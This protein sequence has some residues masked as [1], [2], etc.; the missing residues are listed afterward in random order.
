MKRCFL[1]L[2]AKRSR[3]PQRGHGPFCSN[4]PFLLRRS[5]YDAATSSIRYDR[6]AVLSSS[7]KFDIYVLLSINHPAFVDCSACVVF[8]PSL[9]PLIFGYPDEQ[10]VVHELDLD[11]LRTHRNFAR[12]K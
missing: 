5:P 10:A 1:V 2:I 8:G 3:P 7:T 4:C 11:L 9:A 6:A 12:T